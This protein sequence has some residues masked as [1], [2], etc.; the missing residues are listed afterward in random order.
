MRNGCTV[1]LCVA[2]RRDEG[3][4]EKNGGVRGKAE[5]RIMRRERESA[6][7]GS[8]SKRQRQHSIGDSLSKLIGMLHMTSRNRRRQQEQVDERVQELEKT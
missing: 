6:R 8:L 4:R 2:G 1:A 7:L 3:R 5:F